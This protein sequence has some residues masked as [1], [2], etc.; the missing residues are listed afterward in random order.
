MRALVHLELTGI[1]ASVLLAE[2]LHLFALSA[3]EAG[4]RNSAALQ[5]RAQMVLHWKVCVPEE[6]EGG[7]QMSLS[8]FTVHLKRLG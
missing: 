2:T 1:V 8:S 4:H 3:G 5:H 6:T 7:R